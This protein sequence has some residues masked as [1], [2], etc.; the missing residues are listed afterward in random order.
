M[1]VLVSRYTAY[2]FTGDSSLELLHHKHLE[3]YITGDLSYYAVQRKTLTIIK[4]S[5]HLYQTCS[6]LHL[7]SQ[8]LY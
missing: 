4:L 8:L 2:F 7:N 5:W 3:T 1:L 6:G